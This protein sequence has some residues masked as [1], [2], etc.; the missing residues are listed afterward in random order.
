VVSTDGERKMSMKVEGNTE[1][2]KTDMYKLEIFST[3]GELLGSLAVDHF[4]DG[5]YIKGSR[6]FLWDG[7]RAAKF[8]EY[9]IEAR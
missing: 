5:I 4:V 2:E 9:K 1:V 3:E 8:Y 7:L 6:L